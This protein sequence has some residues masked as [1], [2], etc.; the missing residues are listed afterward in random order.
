MQKWS[1]VGSFAVHNIIR[2]FGET[3]LGSGLDDKTVNGHAGE[4]PYF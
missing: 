2:T 4:Y 1:W 3:R